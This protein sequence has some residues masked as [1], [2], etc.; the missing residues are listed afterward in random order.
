MMGKEYSRR[1][2]ENRGRMGKRTQAWPCMYT[3]IRLQDK[4]WVSPLL[5]NNFCIFANIIYEVLIE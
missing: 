5:T 3:I 1:E 2:G 4:L